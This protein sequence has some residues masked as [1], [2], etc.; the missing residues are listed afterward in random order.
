MLLVGDGSAGRILADVAGAGFE[1]RVLVRPG[2][3]GDDTDYRSGLMLRM[4]REDSDTDY[5]NGLVY[6]ARLAGF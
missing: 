6:E 3:A 4:K 1:R 2:L 5:R